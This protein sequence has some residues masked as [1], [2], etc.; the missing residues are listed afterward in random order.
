MNKRFAQDLRQLRNSV[1]F[2]KTFGCCRFVYNRMLA[3][4]TLHYDST[5]ES[6]YKPQQYKTEFE[7]LS[8]VDSLAL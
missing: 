3:D 2:T 8:E 6:L 1:L 5:K 4:K 7:W